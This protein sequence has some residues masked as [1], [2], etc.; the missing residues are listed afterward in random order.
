MNDLSSSKLFFGI[1]LLAFLMV[2]AGAFLPMGMNYIVVLALMLLFM[3]VV[4]QLLNGNPLAIFINER[5]LMCLSRFQMALWTCAVLAGFFC[6]ALS[7]LRAFPSD[8]NGGALDVGIDWHLWALMGISTTSLVGSP[9][10]LSSKQQ[11]T[12]DP[13]SVAKTAALVQQDSALVQANSQGTL[14]ANPSIADARLTDMFQGDEVGNTAYLDL[15]KIQMFFFTIITVVCFVVEVFMALYMAHDPTA[16]APHVDQLP[17][18]TD[19]VVSLMGISHAGYLASK[20]VDH[21]QQQ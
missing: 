2:L 9:L 1:F 13:Q 14:F 19:G 18:L 16:A 4:G 20:G 21:T 17:S 12:P 6:C 5:N 11:Q 10:L 3:L 7:R 15:A 8:L